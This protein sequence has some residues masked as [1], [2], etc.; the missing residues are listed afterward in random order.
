MNITKKEFTKIVKESVSKSEVCRK[1]GISNNGTGLRKVNELTT[2]YNLDISHFSHKSAMNKFIRKWE[3]VEKVCPVC[4]NKFDTLLNHPREKFTCSHSCSNTF[5]A[6]RRNK[7]EKYKNYRT[8]CFKNWSKKCL[9]CGFDFVVEVHHLNHDH[10]DNRKENLV[11]L[12]PNHHQMLHTSTHG[13][14]VRNKISEI[15]RS[16]A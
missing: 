12:C 2:K 8:I 9:L 1:L 15:L 5:F 16:V 7:P 6:D 3:L 13:E 4:S 10:K 11:P 14:E